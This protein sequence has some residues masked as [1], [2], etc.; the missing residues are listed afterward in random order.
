M[1]PS[2]ATLAL[3]LGSG[4]GLRVLLPGAEP[5]REL[6]AG[7]IVSIDSR[8]GVTLAAAAGQGVWVR[9]GRE[10][11]MT[12]A[13]DVRRVRIAPSGLLLAGTAPAAIHVSTDGDRWEEWSTLQNLL[14][15]H[16]QRLTNNSTARDVGGIAFASGAVV[17]ITGVGAFL[18]LDEGRNWALHSEGLD[19]QVHGLWEHPERTDRLYAASPS[20]F[21][22][23]EDGGYSWVQ[24]LHGLDRS[25]VWDVAVLPGTP[26]TLLLSA[27]RRPDG[28][29][30][31]L[32]RSVD[33]GISWSR[34]LL[35]SED[36]WAQPP[37]VCSLT[38]PVDAL[39][40]LAGRRA[41]GSHD[42]GDHWMP[43]ADG[44]PPARSFIAAVGDW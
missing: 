36:E 41:W 19:R 27:A 37:L 33:G 28:Q 42:R 12:L 11:R 5:R 20:G 13:G 32:F 1:R 31:A 26:D 16:W 34:V 29:E 22:R 4:D 7:P 10:W 2:T 3:L 18:T 40:V 44:L 23:S 25:W 30:S 35:E 38:S 6:T 17:A 24:S 43:I 8:D 9:R 14:R 39:F 21:Y 15:Y